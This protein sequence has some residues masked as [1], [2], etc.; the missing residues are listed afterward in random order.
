LRVEDTLDARCQA[1]VQALKAAELDRAALGAMISVVMPWP[2]LHQAL[3]SPSALVF[4]RDDA[5][6]LVVHQALGQAGIK[7]GL[8]AH[9]SL[10]SAI[11]GQAASGL[12]GAMAATSALTV[13]ALTALLGA[14]SDLPQFRKGDL[15]ILVTTDDAIRNR[16]VPSVTHVFHVRLPA[17][18]ERSARCTASPPS[19]SRGT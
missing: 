15:R 6:A 1:L 2:G 14:R 12:F 7:A 16:D 10:R 5:E 4:C 3:H 8:A 19:V 18:Q 11:G 9:P 13:A 17:S